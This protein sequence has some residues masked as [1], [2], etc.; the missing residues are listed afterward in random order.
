MGSY[1]SVSKPRDQV[2]FQNNPCVN[3]KWHC[4]KFS[5]CDYFGPPLP[6]TILQ[7][8]HSSAF[9]ITGCYNTSILTAEKMKITLFLDVT[10]CRL[11][12]RCQRFRGIYCVHI[13]GIYSA[14][15][16]AEV[17]PESLYLPTRIH[18]AELQK[19]VIFESILACSR[20]LSL[21]HL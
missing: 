19:T 14:K 9:I 15:L 7:I 17:S 18:S 2:Q 1:I 16:R 6:V 4:D 12:G 5:S 21:C 11:A 3:T 8:L 10:P 20:R 13:L